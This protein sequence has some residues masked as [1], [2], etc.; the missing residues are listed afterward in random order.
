MSKFIKCF[1]CMESYALT[2]INDFP[3][4][5][6]CIYTNINEPPFLLACLHCDSR[7]S[8]INILNN[9]RKKLDN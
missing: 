8:K 3:H 1:N 9:I 6:K 5:F 7:K 4:S 2:V